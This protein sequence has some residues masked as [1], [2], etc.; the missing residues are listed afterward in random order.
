[1]HKNSSSVIDYKMPTGCIQLIRNAMSSQHA[2]SLPLTMSWN[3]IPEGQGTVGNRLG[4]S[5]KEEESAEMEAPTLAQFLEEFFHHSW[6]SLHE[7][8]F[9]HEV[10][11]QHPILLLRVPWP[12]GVTFW[13]IM[14]N[15]FNIH[16]IGSNPM[17][18]FLDKEEGP[19]C[20]VY[21]SQGDPR[22]PNRGENQISP[23]NVSHL[24]NFAMTC[25]MPELSQ[26]LWRDFHPQKAWS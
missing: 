22:T 21:F 5:C 13:K 18:L 1:M 20:S 25:E 7:K 12:S 23:L 10:P 6:K 2:S 3:A 17:F 16:F 14:G 11:V 4:S 15:S 19:Q 8:E 24:C 9:H 26:E